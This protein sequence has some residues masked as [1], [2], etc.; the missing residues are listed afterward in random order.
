MI[1]LNNRGMTIIELLASFIIISLV[2]VT[3]YTSLN[4]FS[5]KKV[6]ESAKESIYTYKNLLTKEIYDD[7]IN[8]GLIDVD[9][10]EVTDTV[11]EAMDR[12][13]VHNCA[14]KQYCVGAGGDSCGGT[15]SNCVNANE[16]LL[17]RVVFTF[18]DTSQKLLIVAKNPD[19][20]GKDIIA[21]GKFNDLHIYDLPTYD[22][23][24]L[25]VGNVVSS[26]YGY[27]IYDFEMRFEHPLFSQR[28]GVII[29]AVVNLH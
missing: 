20:D 10:S 13:G 12:F 27:P 6:E 23:N 9:S 17:T 14:N 1:K 29:R 28:Y 8:K 24:A 25:R 21:Y 16:T 3:L 4:N 2:L 19:A 7:I 26:R 11:V 15:G 5:D 22:G 18:K